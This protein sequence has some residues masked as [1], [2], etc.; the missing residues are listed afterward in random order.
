MSSSSQAPGSVPDTSSA[1]APVTTPEGAEVPPT[2]A[3]TLTDTP[4]EPPVAEVTEGAA[5]AEVSAD[6]SF[7]DTA[8]RLAEHFP[9]LFGAPAQPLKLRIQNDIQERAP[10]AFSKQALSAFFRRHTHS[11][12]YLQAVAKGTQR[13][14]LDGQPAGELSDEHRQLAVDE[15]ARRKARHQE[16]RQQEREKMIAERKA[17]FKAQRQEDAQ[18]R[19]QRDQQ[20]DQQRQQHRAEDDARRSRVQLL[21]DFESTRLTESNFCALKGIALADLPALLAQAREDLKAMPP[22]PPRREGDA[23]GPR[24]DGEGRPGREAREARGD[25]RGP[26]RSDG[27]RDGRND[28]RSDGRNEG[29]GGERRGGPRREGQ[30][31]RQ[32]GAKADTS[33]DRKPD[34]KPDN[35]A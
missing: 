27:R 35:K 22:R 4:T 23:R 6:A 13:F 8:R 21:R 1:V 29:R 18:Q 7:A 25:G 11:T 28:G 14:D 20:R 34:S 2:H 12:A 26:G 32:P 16:R 19:Q 10:G 3:D 9:A 31:E 33:P 24:R 30:A 15:L 5:A 17:A